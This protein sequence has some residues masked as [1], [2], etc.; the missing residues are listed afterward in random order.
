MLP[1]LRLYAALLVCAALLAVGDV[2]SVAAIVL[3]VAE[4]LAAAVDGLLASRRLRRLQPRREV[5]DKLALGAWNDV[6]LVLESGNPAARVSLRD[7]PPTDFLA[8]PLPHLLVVPPAAGRVTY[9]VAPRHRGPYAF[10]D[11][12]ARLVGPLGLMAAQRGFPHTAQTVRVYPNPRDL[13]RYELLAR[14]GL[15]AETGTKRLRRPG[16]SLE[17]ETVREYLPDDEYRRINWKATARRG[18]PMV[19]T[20]EAERG[21]NVVLLLDTGRLMGARAR[22][23][24]TEEADALAQ[25][26]VA[27]GQT[28]LDFAVRATMLLAHVASVRG[29]RVGLLAYADEVRRFLPPRRGRIAFLGITAAVYDLQAETVEPDHAAALAYL[30]SRNLR[31]S[32]VV[33]F[34][35]LT[36][37]ETSRALVSAV[38]SAAHHHQVVCV[39][40]GDPTVSQPAR[41]VPRT[42]G[43]LYE[44]MVAGRML[45]ERA[46]VLAILT[47]QGVLCVDTDADHLSP[48]LIAAYLQIKERGRV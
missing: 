2:G 3:A 12:W 39:T 31:R 34:T 13:R 32:L 40:L 9:R 25:G 30:G 43:E 16:E 8:Q 47:R 11:I 42:T 24:E 33:L 44:K 21:Q 20:F 15:L 1:T 14:R 45:E 26:E 19:T 35:D 5:R 29:D 17:P 23:P 48:R 28:K 41:R 46:D 27:T 36:D 4:L 18:S 10:G 7:V 37:P 22:L 6:T 38:A